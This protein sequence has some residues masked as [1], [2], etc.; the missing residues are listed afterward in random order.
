[1]ADLRTRL[2]RAVDCEGPP[3]S[4]YDLMPDAPSGGALTPAAV[5]IGVTGWEDRPRVILTKRSNGLRHHPGQ[6][7]FPGGRCDG[8]ETPVQ[9]AL[10]EAGEEVGLPTD[11]VE[12]IGDLPPHRTVTSFSATPILAVITKPFAYRAEPGEVEEVFDVPLDHLCDPANFIT[13][14]RY[15]QGRMRHYYT[16]PYGPFYIWGATARMLRGLADRLA[17]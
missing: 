17:P 9:A 16:V 13:E 2:R 14:G 12:V 15:W 11:A 1:M 8:D 4:D 5:L 10:R 3:S 7:A 6:V